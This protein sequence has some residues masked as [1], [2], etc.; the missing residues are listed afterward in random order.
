MT[1]RFWR[2]KPNPPAVKVRDEWI[3]WLEMGGQRERTIDGYKRTTDRFLRDWPGIGIRDVT[4]ERVQGFVEASKPAS[5]QSLR[6]PFSNWLSWCFRTGRIDENVML[7]VPT[8]KQPKPP[9]IQVFT[10][11]EIRTLERLPEP[12]GT[13]MAILFGSG[14]RKAEARNL[15][16]KRVDLDNAEI[17]IIEGAKGGSTGVVPISDNLVGRIRVLIEL[18]QLGPDDFLWYSHP[19]G[20]PKR[21]HD[22]ALSDGAMHLWWGKAIEKSGVHYRH[23]HTTRHSYATRWRRRGLTFDDVGDGLRHADPRTTKKVYVHTRSIDLRRRMEAAAG[24]DW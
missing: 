22:R 8:Y 1:R 20:T 18:E 17:H 12:D 13:L 7:R 14:I 5:R 24:N 6:A 3:G 15:S 9:V 4:P 23:M 19:G 10:E 11:K 2:R 16:V 21:R